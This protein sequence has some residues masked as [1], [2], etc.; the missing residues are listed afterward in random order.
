MMDSTN[1]DG[2]RRTTFLKFA[3]CAAT[4]IAVC[5]PAAAPAEDVGD[6]VVC[7]ECNTLNGP[8][9][10]YCMRCGA[11]LKPE[12]E[13][14][15]AIRVVAFTLAPVACYDYHLAGPGLSCRGNAGRWGYGLSYQY[16]P[17]SAPDYEPFLWTTADDVHRLSVSSAFYLGARKRVTPYVGVALEGRYQ[18]IASDHYGQHG[19][20]EHE[21]AV[22]AEVGAGINLNYA[23]RGSNVELGLAIGPYA[24]WESG[25]GTGD[26]FWGATT[27]F[28]VVNVTYIT[29]NV[30][31]WGE[32]ATGTRMFGRW[33]NGAV[34]AAGPAFGW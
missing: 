22:A 27:S 23:A 18:H 34:V 8:E 19:V 7:P 21:F 26:Q 28:R 24:W 3:I 17:V 11:Q 9:A 1:V 16:F 2:A 5:W 33:G 13:R 14:P 29:S 32:L 15:A 25:P 20:Y 6:Y 4:L 31:V 12:G 30:G 10:V